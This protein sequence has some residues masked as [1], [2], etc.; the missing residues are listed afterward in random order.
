MKTVLGRSYSGDRE[1]AALV[2]LAQ[3]GDR[4]ALEALIEKN[5]VWVYNIALRMVGRPE[6]AEDV[7]QEVLIKVITRLSTFEGRSSFRTWLYRIV[8][9]HVLNIRRTLW[10][11]L[12]DTFEKHAKLMDS[13][14]DG[15]PENTAEFEVQSDSVMTA[16]MTGMLLCLDR[17][18]RLVM[19][20]GS[21]FG[22]DSQFG[23]AVL[24]ISPENFRQILSRARKQLK[25]FMSEKC[26]LFDEKNPCRCQAKT[27]AAIQRG[28]VN[29]ENLQFYHRPL[30][31][32]EELIAE[33]PTL[34]E[35]AL[36]I[37]VQALYRKQ[38]L[39]PSPDFVQR[40]RKALKFDPLARIIE[41]DEDG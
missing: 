2:G 34:A 28:I 7:T 26:G 17:Q 15:D 40:F 32:V 31:R 14:E 6:D 1:D 24:D 19:I 13:M 5:Q 18:Q 41:F 36:E 33:N 30:Q 20:L 29:P 8:A 23:A 39:L 21:V 10:E 3:S 4:L 12:D 37:R 27:R 16:C 25:N 35:D 9:N 38:H 22:V 11:R